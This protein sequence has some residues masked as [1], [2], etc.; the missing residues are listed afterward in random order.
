MQT[1][2]NK[3]QRLNA[4]PMR[5]QENKFEFAKTTVRTSLQDS[6]LCGFKPSMLA[7]GFLFVL[8]GCS[9]GA[10]CIER[11]SFIKAGS[12]FAGM[13]PETVFAS[14]GNRL[15]GG[16]ADADRQRWSDVSFKKEVF[17]FEKN[18][19]RPLFR[20]DKMIS[21]KSLIDGSSALVD[22]RSCTNSLKACVWRS[23]FM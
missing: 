16:V 19:V 4:F 22:S 2:A 14:P 9:L 21:S 3:T 8:A 10:P 11:G 13:R 5:I 18:E 12:S 6:A 1:A 17:D 15:F 7:T 23:I 20:F